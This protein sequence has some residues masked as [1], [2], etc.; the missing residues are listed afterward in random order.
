MARYFA[1]L[2]DGHQGSKVEGAKEFLA[3]VQ[4]TSGL[5]ETPWAD[6]DIGVQVS[7]MILGFF[8]LVRPPHPTAH[9]CC[10]QR[11]FQRSRAH[12]GTGRCFSKVE[13]FVSQCGQR[14]PGTGQCANRLFSL[15]RVLS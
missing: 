5:G 4:E 8:A 10:Y 11:Q 13:G 1:L 15:D 6:R 9:F 3:L 12:I 2:I 14:L 7:S